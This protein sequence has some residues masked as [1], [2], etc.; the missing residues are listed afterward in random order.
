MSGRARSQ[1]RVYPILHCLQHPGL[2]LC[3]FDGGRV[4]RLESVGTIVN[5]FQGGRMPNCAVL[6]HVFGCT[7]V[8]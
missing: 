8:C 4:V 5:H 6:L 2:E 1:D 3:T 7:S